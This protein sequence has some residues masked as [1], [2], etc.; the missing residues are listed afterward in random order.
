MKYRQTSGIDRT[1]SKNL[2]VSHLVFQ[3]PLS[4]PLNPGVKSRIKMQLEQR[5]QAMLHLSDLQV[6]CLLGCDL[7]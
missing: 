7:Y 1:K 6:Y 3:L 2:N 4:N 5:R